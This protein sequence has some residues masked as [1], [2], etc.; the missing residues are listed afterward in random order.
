MLKS[1]EIK[2]PGRVNAR[3]GW[4]F[5]ESSSNYLTSLG[6]YRGI[7]AT[8]TECANTN[9]YVNDCCRAQ[10]EKWC[11]SRPRPEA[12]GPAHSFPPAGEARFHIIVFVLASVF[13][14][15]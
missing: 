4:S 14:L 13:D 5:E 6:W 8:K 12:G 1:L 7:Q 10:G 11:G 9:K 3:Q 15:S 2:N